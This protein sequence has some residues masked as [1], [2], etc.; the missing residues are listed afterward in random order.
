MGCGRERRC[1]PFVNAL[2]YASKMIAKIE[3][4]LPAYHNRC[5]TCISQLQ[6]V[7]TALLTSRRCSI[8]AINFDPCSSHHSSPLPRRKH[9]LTISIHFTAPSSFSRRLR[10]CIPTCCENKPHSARNL[11]LLGLFR[12][13]QRVKLEARETSLRGGHFSISPLLP[14]IFEI[15]A[16]LTCKLSFAPDSGGEGSTGQGI[17]KIGKVTPDIQGYT[18]RQNPAEYCLRGTSQTLSI[19]SLE[20]PANGK[21]SE[22]RICFGL[23]FA[24]SNIQMYLNEDENPKLKW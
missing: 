17:S 11:F 8:S 10:V 16:F 22:I 3:H 9:S 5:Y 4:L 15:S 19:C 21:F 14:R 23:F 2:Q 12:V 13:R 20:L 7:K 24:Y 1:L 6:P 18:V